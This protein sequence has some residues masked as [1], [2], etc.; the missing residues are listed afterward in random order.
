MIDIRT[1]TICEDN[2]LP[3]YWHSLTQTFVCG[4]CW[5]YYMSQVDEAATKRARDRMEAEAEQ[6]EF[7]LN[8][9]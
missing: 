5:N 3:T 6:Q 9:C 8:H 4:P 1:C 2:K 7:W